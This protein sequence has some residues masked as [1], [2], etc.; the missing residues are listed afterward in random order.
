MIRI[1]ILIFYSLYLLT[2]P[3]S[4]QD[5]LWGLTQNG[6]TSSAGTAFH[7]R[8]LEKIIKCIKTF[9]LLLLILEV[10][11]IQGNDGNF[12]GMTFSGGTYNRGI[13]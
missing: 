8:V 7:Y 3:S 13:R 4:A 11:L 12:Y 2:Y 9:F 6:G 1:W 5:V 10:S